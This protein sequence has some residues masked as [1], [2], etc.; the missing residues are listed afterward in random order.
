MVVE[1]LF[2]KITR[3]SKCKNIKLS[4]ATIAKQFRL[5]IVFERA[6]FREISNRFLQK[7]DLDLTKII[8]NAQTL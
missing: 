1:L 4:V 3:F 8:V 7:Q 6:W 2:S 5:S